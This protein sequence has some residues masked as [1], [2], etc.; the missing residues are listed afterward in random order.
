MYTY[1][2]FN[3]KLFIKDISECI[4]FHDI[5]NSA[6]TCVE[7]TWDLWL[8]NFTSI[9]DR[10]APL[11]STRVRNKHNPWVT[12]EMVKLMYKR[13]YAHKKAVQAL[14]NEDL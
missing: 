7:S 3:E 6:I 4:A 14:N 1:K 2:N 8:E 11:I 5:E 13:D 12:N 9:C 10:H